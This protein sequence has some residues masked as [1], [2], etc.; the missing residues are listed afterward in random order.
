MVVVKQTAIDFGTPAFSYQ[1]LL[2]ERIYS[3]GLIL[4]PVTPPIIIIINCSVSL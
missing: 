2:A 3:I 1:I 4:T